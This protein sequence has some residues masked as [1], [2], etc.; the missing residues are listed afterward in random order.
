M[1][2]I[3]T[4]FLLILICVSVRAANVTLTWEP[5][6]TATNTPV[7]YKLY[8]SNQIGSMT[9]SYL[10]VGTNLVATATNLVSGETN[11]FFVTAYRIDDT[12]RIE[13]LPSNTVEYIVPKYSILPPLNLKA[14]E[15]K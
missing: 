3:I 9:P 12:N 10:D 8:W 13:S 15:V 1:K 2:R 11:W 14:F 5:S 4:I 6:S 7:A